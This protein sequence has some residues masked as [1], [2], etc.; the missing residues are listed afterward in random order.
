MDI[1]MPVMDGLEATR[2]IKATAQG[3]NT[4]IVALTA[5]SFKEER[6][7]ILSEGCDDFIRKPAR[8]TDILDT[9]TKH[10]NIRFI[11][12]DVELGSVP[13]QLR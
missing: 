5:S 13:Q 10:L 4:I 7:N 8:E 12:Q 3:Q 2:H 9:L 6:E 1:R 11:Y